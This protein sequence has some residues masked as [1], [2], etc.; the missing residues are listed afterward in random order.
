VTTGQ[1]DAF[2]AARDARTLQ[3]G[4]A[5]EALSR[6]VALVIGPRTACTRSGQV[7]A[8]ALVNMLARVHRTLTVV[9]PAVPLRAHSL[10]AGASL[11]QVLIETA[12]AIDPFITVTAATALHGATGGA[13]T[14]GVGDDVP[15]GLSLHVGWTGGRGEIGPTPIATGDREADVVGAATAG[16][17]AA[18]AVFRLAHEQH[19]RPVRLNIVER[20]ADDDAGVTSITGP[21][22]VGD[23]LIVGAGAVTNALLY[24][25]AEIG[26]VGACDVVDGDIA[27][28]HNTNR[29]MAM[30]AAD[31]G[32]PYGIRT[33]EAEQKAVIAAR[34]IGAEPHPLWYHDYLLSHPSRAHDLV[35]P[36]ANEHGV[37]TAIAARGEPILLHATTSPQWTAELHRHIPDR[38]DCP[39]CRIRD[40]VTTR[41]QCSTGPADPTDR[42]SGDAALPF[43]SAAAGLMLLIALRQ[44]SNDDALTRGRT[45]HWHLHL[46]LGHRLWQP[47]THPCG[48]CPHVLPSEARRTL[49]SQRPT[50]HDS[51]DDAAALDA[52]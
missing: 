34:L 12:T 9:V 14:V 38:D 30:T 3:Y 20:T 36:L 13:I 50:P 25:T 10:V 11:S 16:C 33:G 22:R 37:R 39:A 27:E 46:E 41:F 44:L 32:W 47:S 45:N 35:L 17:L 48:D 18:A 49:R 52:P 19:I 31:A 26:F 8:L 2:Y 21:L 40:A 42:T 29:C 6:P 7:F 1:S 28:L 24:W 5:V 23:T 51:L 4:G 15:G 43:L